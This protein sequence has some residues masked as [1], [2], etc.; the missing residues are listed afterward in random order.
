MSDKFFLDT[1]VFLYSFHAAYPAKQAT[2]K[3]L[4]RTAL[5]EGNGSTS[6]QV[7]Q[8]F[9]NVAT[10]KFETP[11]SIPD[12]QRYL[13]SVLEPL[14][15]VFTSIGLYHQALE[16]EDRWQ[17]SFYDAL[18]IASALQI[19]CKVLYSTHLPHG[20]KIQKLTL[21]NPFLESEV[22]T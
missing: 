8:E 14:C 16:L 19:N 21:R 1:N 10:L 2:A 22:M 6:F 12:C 15:E 13:T 17:Y 11:L 7:V 18:V 4:I 5:N 20:Q 9:M 3:R